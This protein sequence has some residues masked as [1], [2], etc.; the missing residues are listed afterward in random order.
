ME[1]VIINLPP[2]NKLIE[3]NK[4]SHKNQDFYS[5]KE[6]VMPSTEMDLLT[7]ILK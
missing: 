3:L 6:F 5:H 2:K 1:K 7:K 4:L